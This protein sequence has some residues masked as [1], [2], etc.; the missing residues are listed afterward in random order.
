MT[1]FRTLAAVSTLGVLAG[2]GT[3]TST[4]GPSPDAESTVRATVPLQAPSRT[5][6]PA[7]KA[8]DLVVAVPRPA[9]TAA[10]APQSGGGGTVTRS[11]EVTGSNAL[12]SLRGDT[13]NAIVYAPLSNP[14]AVTTEGSVSTW[15]AWS[16][17]KVLVIAAY[18]DTV[19]DGDPS[20]I[21]STERGWISAALT[22]S[23]G[24]AVVNI[25]SKI[26]GS[27]GAAINRV[28]RDIGDSTTS[29]PDRSQG[30]MWWSPREQVRFMAALAGGR[31]VSKAASSYLLGQMNPIPQHEWGLGT[32]GARTFKGGWLTSSSETRQMGIV[33]GYAV[34]IIT[35]GV[36]PAVVQTDGDAAHV[37]QM[38]RLADLLA[39][40][41]G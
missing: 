13:R 38:N 32:I 4:T 33:G 29:A 7:P 21:P 1:R 2:C 36:G 11:D 16:T 25:R 15:R 17:S 5:A 22:R 23:D 14:S 37:Q 40:R 26:P 28:L 9:E 12:T 8:Q 3:A 35:V 24:N 6:E 34:A 20:K 39:R 41:L 10:P 19:V 31:V 30:T 27:P 18:L